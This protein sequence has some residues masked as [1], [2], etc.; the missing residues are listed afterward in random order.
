MKSA[1]TWTTAVQQ[2]VEESVEHAFE[3]LARA[4]VD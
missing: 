4:A 2:M 1:V 3:D